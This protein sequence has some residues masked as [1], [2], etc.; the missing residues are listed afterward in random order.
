M[1]VSIIL[2]RITK[3]RKQYQVV[4]SPACHWIGRILLRYCRAHGEV[5]YV[6]YS[7]KRRRGTK[8]ISI[9]KQ[10]KMTVIEYMAN[11]NELACFALTIMPTDDERKRKFMVE[12]RISVAKQI[13]SGSYR[14]VS[15][16]DTV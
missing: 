10:G 9:L 2:T 8:A 15:F 7:I 16:A 4:L 3:G 1:I 11:F 14:L 5:Q 6:S 12:L 13:D